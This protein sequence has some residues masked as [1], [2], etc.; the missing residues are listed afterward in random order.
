MRKCVFDPFLTQFWSQDSPFSRRFGIC[1]GP[2][3]I[4]TG[5]N[6]AKNACLSIPNGPS[7][8]LENTFFTLF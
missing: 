2:K 4:T 6:L 3:R 8:L 7:Y 5:S 1:H